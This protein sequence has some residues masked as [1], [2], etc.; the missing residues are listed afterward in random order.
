MTEHR[1]YVY[2]TTNPAKTVLYTGMTNDLVRR[3]DEHRQNRGKP[4]TFAG[5]YFCFNLIYWEHHLYVNRAIDREK[6]LK[7]WTRARKNALISEENPDW[8]FLNTD[9]QPG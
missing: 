3:M 8:R 2:M 5:R 7:G 6:E 1:Y 9:I 4:E